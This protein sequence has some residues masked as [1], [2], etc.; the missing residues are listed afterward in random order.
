[1]FSP[2]L[3]LTLTLNAIA[4]S[5]SSSLNTTNLTQHP[6]RVAPRFISGGFYD[7]CKDVR[8]Y[9]AKAD[10]THPRKNSFNGYKS[11]PWLVAKCPD[12]N[13]KYLCT[14]LALSKCLLNSEGELYRGSNGN[15]HG[16]CTAYVAVGAVDGY[17]TCHGNWGILD[18]CSGRPSQDPFL[19]SK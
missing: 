18:Y 14:W 8:F 3:L 16:S 7:K 2:L 13:G 4:T 1:M 10:D 19:D 11:S 9:L 17:L 6:S 12:K 15:F 5:P